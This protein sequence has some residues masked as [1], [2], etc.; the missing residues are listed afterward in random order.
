MR[1]NNQIKEPWFLRALTTVILGK[2]PSI[3]GT[4]PSENKL[5]KMAI[6]LMGWPIKLL[7]CGM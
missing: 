2:K 1:I 6:R 5:K 4:P 7:N 3:G